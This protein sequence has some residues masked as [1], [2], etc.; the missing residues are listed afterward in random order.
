[1]RYL[2][3]IA[4]AV[5]F[6]ALATFFVSSA[7]ASWVVR[8]FTFNSPDAADGLHMATFMA[9][10]VTALILGFLVGWALGVRFKRA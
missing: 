2:L 9:S 6:S 8:Q 3:A 4:T 10:N 5:L 7:V 1:M